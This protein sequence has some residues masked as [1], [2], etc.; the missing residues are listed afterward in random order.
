MQFNQELNKLASILL[1]K[2][3]IDIYPSGILGESSL[4]EDGFHYSFLLD[5]PISIKELPKVLKQMRKNIDRG[6]KLTYESISYA[7]AKEL[8]AKQKYKLEQ[9]QG[10][11]KV[12]IVKFGYDFIDICEEL[13]IE[14]LS[15]I[16]VIDLSN[17]AGVY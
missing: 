3:I 8:F 13:K 15:Q 17:V 9:I 2:S 16:K 11:D 12:A 14:K 6:Y 1:A 7:K 4:T 10:L 5:T